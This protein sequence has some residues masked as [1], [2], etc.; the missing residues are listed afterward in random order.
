MPKIGTIIPRNNATGGTKSPSPAKSM[1]APSAERDNRDRRV[2]RVSRGD[3]LVGEIVAFLR[4]YIV[5]PDETLVVAA[6]WVIAAWL[7]EVWDRFPHLAVTSPEKRCGKTHFLRLLEH[8]VPNAHNTANISPAAIYRLIAHTQEAGELLTLLL[9]EAQSLARKGSEQSEVTGELLNASIDRNAVV[10]RCA[11]KDHEIKKFPV[12]CAKAIA[13]IGALNSVLADRCLPVAMKRKTDADHVDH[14]RSRL[15]QPEADAL[16]EKIEAWAKANRD[17]I[18]D[19]Y[20]AAEPFA[21]DNDRMAELLLPL[22]AVLTVAGQTGAGGLGGFL[23]G[24]GGTYLN[25][26]AGYA[27]SL[28]E[29]E[30]EEERMSPGVRLLTACRDIFPTFRDKKY[31]GFIPTTNLLQK[32]VERK[33]EPWATYRRGEPLNAETL[34]NLLRPYGIRSSKSKDQKHRG[35]YYQ[36]FEEAFGRYVAPLPPISPPNPPKSVNATKPAGRAKAKAKGGQR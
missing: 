17:A 31:Q 5:L 27:T 19:V 11:G 25:V 15:V 35:Y 4:R 20:D 9:D 30:K 28:D 22:Q 1:V 29:R 14:Y 3:A 10:I 34:G 2:R 26:L 23:E 32:L 18:A 36:D 12:Y 13:T 6:A 21:I 8:L 33:E 7:T 24:C 16:K